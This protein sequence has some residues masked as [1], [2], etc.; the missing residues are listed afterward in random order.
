MT[1]FLLQR[2]TRHVHLFL[3]HS[4]YSTSQTGDGVTRANLPLSGIR[5]LEVGLVI[6]GPF[7]GQLLG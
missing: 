4:Y 1:D 5:V 6:A 2:H 3:Y 7:C